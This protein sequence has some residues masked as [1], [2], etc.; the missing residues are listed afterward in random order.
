MFDNL[1]RLFVDLFL[2][3]I[4]RNLS[5]KYVNMEKIVDNQD[6]VYERKSSYF[7]S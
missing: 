5:D 2:K 7:C 3:K 1:S 4:G 6:S